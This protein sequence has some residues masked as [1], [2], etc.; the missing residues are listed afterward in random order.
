MQLPLRASKPAVAAPNCFRSSN[1]LPAV[2]WQ[3]R[4]LCRIGSP[5]PHAPDAP[6]DASRRRRLLGALQVGRLLQKTVL[7]LVAGGRVVLAPGSEWQWHV[8]GGD[9]VAAIAES[10]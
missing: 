6:H 4:R 10:W 2:L 1:Q 3:A 5:A 8:A 9:K 7:G